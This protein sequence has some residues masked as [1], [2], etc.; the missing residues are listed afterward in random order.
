MSKQVTQFWIAEALSQIECE[1]TTTLFLEPKHD[2]LLVSA[3]GLC[4]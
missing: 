3:V 4:R 1:T 2:D